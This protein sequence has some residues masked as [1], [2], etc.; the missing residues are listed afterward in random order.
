MLLNDMGE[1]R[2]LAFYERVPVSGA[3]P[4]EIHRLL[5][6]AVPGTGGDPQAVIEVSRRR[7]SPAATGADFSGEDQ[8]LLEQLAAACA[9]AITLAFGPNVM[10]G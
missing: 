8:A 2:R 7:S 5:A 3:A 6:V 1:T 4:A 9:S 10:A